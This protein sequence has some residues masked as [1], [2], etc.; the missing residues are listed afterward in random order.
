MKSIF[1]KTKFLLVFTLLIGINFAQNNFKLGKY[2]SEALRVSPELKMLNSKLL[3]SKSKVAQVSNLPDPVLKFGVNNLPVASFAFDEEAMTGK[4]IGLS[5]AIPFPGKLSQ[6]GNIK[7]IDVEIV[8][9]EIADKKN[10][11]KNEFSQ[12]YYELI[13]LRSAIEYSNENLKLL[14]SIS[15]V[16][17]SKYSV[18]KASQQNVI[19]VDEEITSLRTKIE[20]LRGK[21]NAVIAVLNSFLL[22]DSKSKIETGK[23]SMIPNFNFTITELIKISENNRP[24]LKGIKKAKEKSK[25]LKKLF[26]YDYYPNFAFSVQ[27][28]QRGN[29]AKTNSNLND[30]LSGFISLS[31]PLNYGGKVTAKV[32]EAE[33]KYDLYSNQY[34]ASLQFLMK[35]FG[36]SVSKI[37]ELK[38]REKLIEQGLLK[39]A[40]QS[41]N[42][43]L[44]AYQVNEIDFYNVIAAENRLLNV[45]IELA[46][47]R[48]DYYK[49]ISLLE[50]L[51]GS[52]LKRDEN[53]YNG[54]K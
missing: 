34:N 52:S 45:Q 25:E 40:K 6:A 51:T 44:A 19:K 9:E 36:K 49:E 27:Y 15:K 7:T 30:F 16:V 39:Q 48:T 10:R 5:Q 18:S 22:A 31:I 47:I 29:F 17:R 46:K 50:F 20:F 35:A 32:N 26:E 28:T 4:V 24:F 12:A 43:A 8:E 41:L 37:L 3:V 14:E 21:E 53:K 42:A 54:E 33:Y 23:I 11:I 38:E 2:V 13:Y 1:I